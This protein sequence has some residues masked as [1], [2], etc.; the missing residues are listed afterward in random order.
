MLLIMITMMMMMMM[1]RC[2]K[3]DA[4]H[5]YWLA[6]LQSVMYSA[7]VFYTVP[8]VAARTVKFQEQCSNGG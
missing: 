4:L 5:H 7:C 6:S 1:K 2:K 3:S 8:T